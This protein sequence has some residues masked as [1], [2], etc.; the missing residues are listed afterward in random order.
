M[1]RNLLGRTIAVTLLSIAVVS[2]SRNANTATTTVAPS[3]TTGEPSRTTVPWQPGA[4]VKA[5]N[6]FVKQFVTVD[7]SGISKSDC[8]VYA[9]L[10]TEGSLT[11][12]MWNGVRWMDISSDLGGGKGAMPLKVYTHDFTNDGALDFFVT[13]GDNR[14]KGGSIYGAYF[15]FPWSGENQCKWNWVDTD[16]GQS[17][18]K[19]VDRPDVDQRHGIVYANGFKSGY[20]T[21]GKFDYLPSTGSFVFAQVFN[22]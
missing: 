1:K 18:T 22:K 4:A 21:Y 12:Y 9:M 16:N 15:A 7:V 3:T 14:D 8:G 20:G 2:C 10:I 5:W 13:Y 17:I 6:K 11:F 19:I